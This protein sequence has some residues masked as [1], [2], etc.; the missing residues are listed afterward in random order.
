MPLKGRFCAKRATQILRSFKVKV[1][2]F[3]LESSSIDASS[4]LIAWPPPLN[5]IRSLLTPRRD[6]RF[7]RLRHANKPLR[8]LLSTR[9]YWLLVPIK[10]R[11]E[12]ECPQNSRNPKEKASFGDMNTRTYSPTCTKSK[13]VPFR[14]IGVTC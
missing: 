12:V 11:L 8:K 2:P 13:L 6:P 7:E 9:Q 1:A 5:H 3:L 10:C 4:H 14:G